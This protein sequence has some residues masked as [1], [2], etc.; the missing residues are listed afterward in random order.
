MK[1]LAG[2]S[3]KPLTVPVIDNVTGDFLPEDEGELK[4]TLAEQISKPVLWH[5]GVQRLIE[6]GCSD[7]MEMGYGQVLTMFGVFIDNRIRTRPYSV[8]FDE[9]DFSVL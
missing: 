1:Y 6:S 8:A 2:E 9:N 7:F 3:I 5:A 4:R